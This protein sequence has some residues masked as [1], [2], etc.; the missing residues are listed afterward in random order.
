MKKKKVDF[1]G[2]IKH[3]TLVGQADFMPKS[4]ALQ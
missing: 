3:D 2:K 1:C 4:W